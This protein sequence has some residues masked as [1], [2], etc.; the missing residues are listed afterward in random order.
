MAELARSSRGRPGPPRRPALGS[1]PG[2][3]ETGPTVSRAA[4]TPRPPRRSRGRPPAGGRRH[5]RDEVPLADQDEGPDRADE[6]DDRADDHD[7]VERG[8][9]ADPV[10][11]EQG[12]ARTQPTGWRPPPGARRLRGWQPAAPAP[13]WATTACPAGVARRA[14]RVWCWIWVWKTEPS[15][16]MPVAMPTWRKV[17]LAPEAMPLRSGGT[18]EMADEASTGLT[19]PIPMPAT[20][21]PGSSTVQAEVAWVVA[22]SRQPTAIRSRPAPSRY[23]DWIRTVSLPAMGATMKASMVRGRKRTPAASGP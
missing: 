10:G 11:V 5:A 15:P 13:P 4:V 12:L 9:E 21:N 1:G 18:T 6:G 8:R 17:L 23:R 22:I 3:P 14:V 19:V 16:A 2:G 7:V 20:T